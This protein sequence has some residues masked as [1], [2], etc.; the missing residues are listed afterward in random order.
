MLECCPFATP[1]FAA[2]SPRST[3]KDLS[4]TEPSGTGNGTLYSDEGPPIGEV[5]AEPWVQAASG[6]GCYNGAERAGQNISGS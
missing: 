4:H 5:A 1:R 6:R 3:L 2:I